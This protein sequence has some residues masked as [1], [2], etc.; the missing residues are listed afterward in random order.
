VSIMPTVSVIIPTYNRAS[1]VKEAIESVLEQSYQDFE[2]IVVDDG[3]TDNT[4]E[5]VS[6]LSEKII[7]L[8]QENHGVSSARNHGIQQARGKY[9]AFLDSDDLFLPEKLEKQVACMENNPEVILSH[10]SYQR[11]DIDGKYLKTVMS[12]TFSGYVYPKIIKRCTIATPTVLVRKTSTG[13]ELKFQEEVFPGEDVILWIR[14]ARESPILGIAEPLTQVRIHGNN[15][16]T[17][18]CAQINGLKNIM[19][20]TIKRQPS[21]SFL[22]RYKLLVYIHLV[23]MLNYFKKIIQRKF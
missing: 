21:L 8:F 23:I 5:I 15:V 3:S 22:I 17:D 13:P 14:L 2:I 9:I 12:G 1:M 4:R 6:G 20:Y 7:Y 18:P 11:I 10:T 16:A 19:E